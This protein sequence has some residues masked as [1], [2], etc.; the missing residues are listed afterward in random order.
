MKKKFI[1]ILTVTALVLMGCGTGAATPATEPAADPAV[2]TDE[3]PE[4]EESAPETDEPSV[5]M[6]NPWVDI[7]E[8]EAANYL[9]RMFTPPMGAT[10]IHWMALNPGSED[11]FPGPLIQMN[12]DVDGGSFV[13]RGQYGAKED[14]DISGMYYE[15]DAPKEVTLDNWGFGEMQAKVYGFEN[16]SEKALLCTW[17]D[18]EVGIAYS[19]STDSFGPDEYD[20]AQLAGEICAVEEFIP[21]SFVEEKVGKG[22]FES[23]DEVLSYLDPG[24]GY[25]YLELPGA[26]DKVLGISSEP[27]EEGQKTFTKELCLYGMDNG[28]VRNLGNVYSDAHPLLMGD[29]TIVA[30]SDK[31]YEEDCLGENGYVMVKVYIYKSTEDDGSIKYGG[32]IRKDNTFDHD[33][34]VPEDAADLFDQY[35]K[36]AAKLK[37][38][39]LTLVE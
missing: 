38:I 5:G 33:E 20:I 32:F 19:L 1:C 23:T 35:I 16:E 24:Q 17:Y 29:G 22:E 14:D 34:D 28:K 13:A 15:W 3:V 18:I 8:E 30:Y 9:P 6:A 2:A 31:I 27:V 39:E 26:P 4:E 11:D 36:D 21:G 7:T 10:K 25:T 37:P 12:F